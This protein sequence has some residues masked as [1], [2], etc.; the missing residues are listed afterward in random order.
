[1]SMELLA[2]PHLD[3]FYPDADALRRAR[4]QQLEGVVTVLPWIATIDAFQHWL[5]T[6]PDHTRQE[7]QDTWLATLERFGGDVDWTGLD[8]AKAYRWQAQL[9]LYRVPFY[10]VEYGIAQVGALGMW[11]RSQQ[12]AA[13]AVTDYRTAL[14][15]GGSRPLPELFSAA[16]VRFDF[17]APVLRPLIETL[18]DALNELDE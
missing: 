4:R 12:D 1:M 3:E 8:R 6:H 11:T 13:Q 10:Y 5:Y 7:R 18:T 2:L 17:S 15:L 14:A 9:H 16:G